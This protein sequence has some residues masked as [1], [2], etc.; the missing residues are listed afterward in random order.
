MKRPKTKTVATPVPAPRPKTYTVEVVGDLILERIVAT[1]ES[2]AKMHEE[3]LK[4][5]GERFAE[6]PADALSWSSN[7]FKY[8]AEL[9][10]A[11]RVLY[12]VKVMAAEGDGTYSGHTGLAVV[13]SVYRELREETMRNARWPEHSTSAPSNEIATRLMAARAEMVVK[14]EDLAWHY[15]LKLEVGS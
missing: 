14:I 10:V 9:S 3:S 8:A 6:N 15:G 2:T 5:W 13:R 12:H 1:A 4:K 7:T 11:R